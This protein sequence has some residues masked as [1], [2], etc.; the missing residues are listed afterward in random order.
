MKEETKVLLIV[1]I[2]SF[3]TPFTGSSVNLALPAIGAEL[4]TDAVLLGWVVEA[5]LLSTA[6]FLL[7]LGRISDF[8][9]KRFIFALGAILFALTSFAI[10]FAQSIEMIIA[11]RIL[12]GAATAMIFSNGM[13]ILTL[14]YPPER[15]GW[16]LGTAASAVYVGLS[17]GPVLGGMLNH[18]FGWRSIFYFVG[19][20]GLAAGFMTLKF[21]KHEWKL[22][23][24]SDFDVA[25]SVIYI[26]TVI[27]GLYGTSELLRGYWGIG[28]LAISFVFL[29]GFIYY[30]NK[31]QNPLIS[32]HLFLTNRTFAFSNLAA[33]INYSATF[34]VGYILSVF[35]QIV[36]GLDSQTAGLILLI[37]PLIM[38]MLSPR[39]GALSDQYDAG[40]LASVGMA[41]SCVSLFVLFGA[42]KLQLSWL[43]GLGLIVGG[44]GFSLFAPPNNNAIMSSVDKKDL[45]AASAA[46]NTARLVGQ[47]VSLSIVNL[48]VSYYRGPVE[49]PIAQMP[50]ENLMGA[51]SFSLIAFTLICALGII[52]SRARKAKRI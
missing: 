26:I 20:W 1:L 16:A 48:I 13:T 46:L 38:A 17:L 44:I 28:S 42:T 21:M 19:V 35:L 52:P 24:V 33:M 39:T 32:I 23:K 30:E 6:A 36:M 47:A 37:Q 25:G 18:Y 11:I 22:G 5:F 43:I 50:L 29:L 3:L 31:Q 15:R 8:L 34:A 51:I 12:Q 14:V 27:T 41:I 10:A 2:V 7:P 40:T 45:G 49:M 4:H 9:G